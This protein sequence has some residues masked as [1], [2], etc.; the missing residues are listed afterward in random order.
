MFKGITY[1]RVR[2]SKVKLHLGSSRLS[3]TNSET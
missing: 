3:L 2:M 1:D